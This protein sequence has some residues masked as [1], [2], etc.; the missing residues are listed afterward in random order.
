MGNDDAAP[1]AE[2]GGR[3]TA[4]VAH[5]ELSQRRFPEGQRR[6]FL[7]AIDAFSERGFHATTTR[8]IAARAGLSP[9]G[10]YVHFGSKEEVLY[11]ISISSMRLT[12]QVATAAAADP[13][14]AATH[15]TAVVRDLTVWHAEHAASVKVVLH[16]LTDLTPEHRSEVTDIQLAIHRLV[17]DLVADG[18]ADGDFEVTDTHATTLALMSL[19]VDTARWYSPDYRRTPDQ[20]GADYATLALRM[21][22][23]RPA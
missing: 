20:I 2:G 22:G 4:A 16:H 10:L 14:T 13:G 1:N 6:I 12:L 7:A 15:L 17:R 18:V 5:L 21:V 19:C 3:D 9:A 8:D 11:R 23:A